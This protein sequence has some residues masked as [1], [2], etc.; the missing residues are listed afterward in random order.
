[1]ALW[2]SV[3]IEQTPA[4]PDGQGLR[5]GWRQG[6][7]RRPPEAAEKPLKKIFKS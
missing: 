2:Q 6:S 3:L 1:L 5:V 4:V 7:N